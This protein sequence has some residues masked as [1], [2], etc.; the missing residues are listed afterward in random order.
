M[1]GDAPRAMACQELV[2][3]VTDY[4]EGVLEPAD[5]AAFDAHIAGCDACT[6]Y[7]EQMRPT[8][9]TLGHLPPESVEPGRGAGAAA[10]FRDW[11][12]RRSAPG[13]RS[14]APA[15]GGLDA[16]PVAGPQFARGLRGKLLAVQEVPSGCAVA[17]P[18]AAAGRGAAAR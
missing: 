9:T 12:S 16:Q 2:E 6:A 5:V 13:R 8:I 10:A 11:R 14:V 18:G 1:S 15:A 7:L 4:F 3:L 17:T